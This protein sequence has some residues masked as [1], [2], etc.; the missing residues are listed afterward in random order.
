MQIPGDCPA[1]S[2]GQAYCAF[3]DLLTQ[4]EHCLDKEKHGLEIAID[5]TGGFYSQH[6]FSPELS[7]DAAFS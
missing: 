6:V 5:V 3:F 4:A 1:E 7:E 2:S